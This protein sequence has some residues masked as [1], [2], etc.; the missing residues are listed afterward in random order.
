MNIWQALDR[1]TSWGSDAETTL[2]LVEKYGPGQPE[3]H[4]KIVEMMKYVS[5]RSIDRKHTDTFCS[6]QWG[7]EEREGSVLF[8]NHLKRIDAE[9][10]AAREAAAAAAI[11]V[12]SATGMG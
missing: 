2:A 11:A 3:E 12:V 10:K 4:P 8:L 6:G 9:H 5:H 7:P 1:Q